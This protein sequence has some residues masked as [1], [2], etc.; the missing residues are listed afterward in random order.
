ML[1]LTIAAT[2]MR[3][4]GP[5]V[6]LRPLG[7]IA[8]YNRAPICVEVSQGYAERSCLPDSPSYYAKPE[9]RFRTL[10]ERGEIT[11]YGG[12]DVNVT[13]QRHTMRPA[14]PYDRKGP[15]GCLTLVEHGPWT[16][17]YGCGIESPLRYQGHG[18]AIARVCD[19]VDR[20]RDAAPPN[21]TRL[22]C[23][24][25][26]LLVGLRRIGVEVRIYSKRIENRRAY[27]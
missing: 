23:D 21:T 17:A 25:T 8:R 7:R 12:L 5:W 6:T 19:L 11:T 24:L 9:V 4:R 14:D 16:G 20:A 15:G 1:A 10:N 27:R 18:K 26:T 13:F 3:K 2:V 22:G